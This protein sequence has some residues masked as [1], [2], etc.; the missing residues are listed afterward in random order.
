M[1]K[2]DFEGVFFNELSDIT[3]AADDF[4]DFFH[5]DGFLVRVKDDKG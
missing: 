4:A 1:A 3:E 5:D 2:A